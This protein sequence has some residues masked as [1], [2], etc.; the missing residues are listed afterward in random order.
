V[1]EIELQREVAKRCLRYEVDMHHTHQ[2]LQDRAG[3][4]DLAL[5]GTKRVMFREL[6][7]RTGKV[8]PAQKRTGDR[9]IA[10]GL[11]YAVWRPADLESGRVD[12]ELAALSGRRPWTQPAR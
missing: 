5:L 9:L 7:T 6:K 4:V 11:D 12:R 3:W 8:S 10:A 1:R 2:P